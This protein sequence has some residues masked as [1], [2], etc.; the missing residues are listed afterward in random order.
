ME[1][2]GATSTNWIYLGWHWLGNGAMEIKG[3]VYLCTDL[4]FTSSHLN[5]TEDIKLEI[6]S[7]AEALEMV[8]TN[9][10]TDYRTKLGLLMAKQ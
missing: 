6:V 1:E 5:E 4:L 9:A 8:R 10:F 3:H 2:A 7:L